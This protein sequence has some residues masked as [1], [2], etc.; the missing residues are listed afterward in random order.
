MGT[1]PG[2]ASYRWNS[3]RSRDKDQ[4]F[5]IDVS[6]KKHSVL[7]YDQRLRNMVRQILTQSVVFCVKEKREI[8]RLFPRY[9]LYGVCSNHKNGICWEYSIS[10]EL[11][12][13]KKPYLWEIQVLFHDA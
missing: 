2:I 12:E 5:V 10:V 1:L 3:V 8:L 6:I 13:Y 7:S 11:E 9:L 4:H